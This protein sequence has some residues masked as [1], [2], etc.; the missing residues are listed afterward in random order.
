MPNPKKPTPELL[1]RRIETIAAVSLR[2]R[3]LYDTDPERDG[4]TLTPAG[5]LLRKH[6]EAVASGAIHTQESPKR[7]ARLSKAEWSTLLGVAQPE[8]RPHFVRAAAR[9]QIRVEE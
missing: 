9:G 6:R 7:P 8:E 2:H 4:Y 1:P 5:H 3:P